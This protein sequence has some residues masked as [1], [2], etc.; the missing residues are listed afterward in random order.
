MTK[1]PLLGYMRV[2]Y[3]FT[4]IFFPYPSVI[5]KGVKTMQMR[6]VYKRDDE[7]MEEMVPKLLRYCYKCGGKGID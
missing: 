7:A 5:A 1:T 3:T 2:K 6:S 4:H